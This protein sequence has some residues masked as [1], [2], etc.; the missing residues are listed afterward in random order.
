[1]HAERL[2][3]GLTSFIC[4]AETSNLA[5]RNTIHNGGLQSPKFDKKQYATFPL[6]FLQP[7]VIT[8]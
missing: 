1:M 3:P 7:P 2:K 8:Q 5:T 4:V 6:N